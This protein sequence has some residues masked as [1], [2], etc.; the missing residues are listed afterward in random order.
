MAY[1]LEDLIKEVKRTNELLE[2]LD[3]RLEHVWPASSLAN[4]ETR[5]RMALIDD[6]ISDPGD[7]I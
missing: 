3:R 4:V 6:P 5:K 1:R 7:F 2:S